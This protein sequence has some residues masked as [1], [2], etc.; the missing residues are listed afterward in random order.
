MRFSA[1]GRNAGGST[2]L[3]LASIYGTAGA[4]NAHLREIHVVNVVATAHFLKLVRLSTAGT[5]GTGL[6]ESF[7]GGLA[8]DATSG[9]NVVN[10]HTVAPTVSADLGYNVSLGA[11]IGSG[12]VWTF[13]GETGL[14]VPAGTANGIGILL[15]AGTVA[16]NAIDFNFVWD[17]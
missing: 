4:R 9:M 13:G 8:A 7:H 17:E 3:P 6:T 12:W 5:Q 10:S 15:A 16:A 11:A 2:T 14:V 1:G